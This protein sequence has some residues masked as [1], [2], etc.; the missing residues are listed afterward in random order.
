MKSMF[1][2]NE[3]PFLIVAWPSSVYSSCSKAESSIGHLVFFYS[4]NENFKPEHTLFCRKLRFIAIYALFGDLWA[5]KV[6]FWV[7]NSVSWAR[8]ALL[9]SI[10]C[11]FHWVI[12]QLCDYAQKQ[13]IWRKNCKYA[14][15]ENFH[16][17]F[18]S[19]RKAA[20][21]CHPADTS[22]GYNDIDID[23]GVCKSEHWGNS[24]IDCD[25]QHSQGHQELSSVIIH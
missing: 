19:R 25:E 2:A 7:K 18:C 17:H 21:F 16:C 24:K 5:K 13:R 1:W 23:F 9:H 6:P 11:I 22:N 4:G 10:Y 3:K 20:K 8:S 15:D 14:L 12:L